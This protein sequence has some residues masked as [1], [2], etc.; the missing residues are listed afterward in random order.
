MKIRKGFVLHD[1]G[2]KKV[3]IATGEAADNFNG[4]IKLNESATMLWK[5]IEK[6]AD[7]EALADK[8]VEN[9]DVDRVTA[10]NDVS[11]FI[12]KLKGAGIIDE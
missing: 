10:L 12:T 3:V 4:I 2:G 11:M 5:L 8:M 7:E 1:I 6:G 9:Y